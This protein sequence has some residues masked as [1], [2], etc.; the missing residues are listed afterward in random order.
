MD[1]KYL[2][3]PA[4]VLDKQNDI[5]QGQNTWQVVGLLWFLLA[6]S[7]ARKFYIQLYLP[8]AKQKVCELGLIKSFV[9]GQNDWWVQH[10]PKC[11]YKV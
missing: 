4:A 2:F 9:R 7:Q 3:C 10:Y 6:L 8:F 1:R 11:L 5:G